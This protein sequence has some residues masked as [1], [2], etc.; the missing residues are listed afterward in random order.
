MTKQGCGGDIRFREV[1]IVRVK[2]RNAPVRI[3]EPLP[4]NVTLSAGEEEDLERYAEAL[5]VF[6]EGRFEDAASMFGALSNRDPVA[7][8]MAGRAQE[9]KADPPTDWDEINTLLSK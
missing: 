4:L 8:A 7:A 6:R 3:F 1:D 9:L 5:A 2:G